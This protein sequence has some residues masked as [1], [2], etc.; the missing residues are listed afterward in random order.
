LRLVADKNLSWAAYNHNGL[1]VIPASDEGETL[2]LD[3]R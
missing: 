1:Y 3:P 2:F